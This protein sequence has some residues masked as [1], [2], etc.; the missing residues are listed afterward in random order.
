MSIV[1]VNG[2]RIRLYLL[3]VQVIAQSWESIYCTVVC[4]KAMIMTNDVGMNDARQ[5]EI[6][7]HGMMVILYSDGTHSTHSL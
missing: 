7:V 5:Y 3:C 6:V 1:R 4:S 2:Y